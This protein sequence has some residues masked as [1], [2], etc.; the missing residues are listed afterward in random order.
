[1]KTFLV[2][3]GI[4]LSANVC[5]AQALPEGKGRTIA[6]WTSYGTAGLDLT[7]D[8]IRSFRRDSGCGRRFL[9]RTATTVAISEVTKRLVHR[10]R[11]DH[12]DNKS[13]FSE[14]TAL[15]FSS[16]G[17]QFQL[18]VPLGSTT[19]LLRVLAAKHHPTDAV[20]GAG[21]GIGTSFLFRCD[22]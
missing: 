9:Y 15:A 11:P 19:G 14:H 13:F 2:A 20:F 22:Q 18:S 8:G 7:F 12:S 4:V 17:L 3:V 16:T 21:V 10:D 1:M 5:T 6:D